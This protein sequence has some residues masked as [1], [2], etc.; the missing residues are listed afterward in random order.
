MNIFLL[1]SSINNSNMS[2]SKRTSNDKALTQFAR[3]TSKTGRWR[4]KPVDK[5]IKYI[6]KKKMLGF[7]SSESIH[8]KTYGNKN[9]K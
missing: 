4:G 5:Y 6:K 3:T 1:K 2:K 7:I 9:I 8:P